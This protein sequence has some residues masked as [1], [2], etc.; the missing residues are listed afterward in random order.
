MNSINK[1]P[2][3]ED[4]QI[5]HWAGFSAKKPHNIFCTFYD[6]QND[7]YFLHF[8]N[9]KRTLG[10]Y[11]EFLG[12]QFKGV[13]NK[14]KLHFLNIGYETSFEDFLRSIRVT[15]IGPN[16]YSCKTSMDL[17]K[18]LFGNPKSLMKE[19]NISLGNNINSFVDLGYIQDQ[20]IQ[21]YRLVWTSLPCALKEIKLY[22]NLGDTEDDSKWLSLQDR[23]KDATI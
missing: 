5:L 12:V 15:I 21:V 17:P 13:I 6:I 22:M 2:W 18:L 19:Q 16:K 10:F 7:N 9:K 8:I 23:F 1:V 14:R 11:G 20:F 3:L 4:E